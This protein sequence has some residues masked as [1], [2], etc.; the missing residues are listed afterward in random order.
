M[1]TVVRSLPFVG[2]HK[3]HDLLYFDGPILSH[4]LDSH[5]RHVLFYWT[6]FDEGRLAHRWLVWRSELSWILDYLNRRISLLELLR[7]CGGEY[8]YL[9]YM[10]NELN[11]Q[12]I[13]VCEFGEISFEYL[14]PPAVYYDLAIPERYVSGEMIT[15]V[16]RTPTE[17]LTK[18]RESSVYFHLSPRE[19]SHESSV[20]VA[21]AGMFLRRIA[22]SW[23]NF[24]SFDFFDSFKNRITDLKHMQKVVQEMHRRMDPRI[25]DLDYRSFMVGVGVDNI[26][27]IGDND[28]F[29]WQ[30]E[31]VGKYREEVLLIDYSSEE[32][33]KDVRERVAPDRIKLVYSP[34]I[35]IMKSEEYSLEVKDVRTKRVVRYP[36]LDKQRAAVLLEQPAE[37]RSKETKLM[38]IVVEVP[39]NE[40]VTSIGKKQ[41]SDGLLFAQPIDDTVIPFE[42]LT[43]QGI[44]VVFKKPIHVAIHK[45][46]NYYEAEFEDLGIS[47]TGLSK[48]SIFHKL[49]ESVVGL[50]LEAQG[51]KGQ[52]NPKQERL[53]QLVA[54]ANEANG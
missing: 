26:I 4:F 6:G 14:P 42:K 50:Y 30:K 22:T 13:D 37:P 8:Y 34:L 32:V 10:D 27:S 35:D 21:D 44:Q 15:N 29:V 17:Y 46:A 3:Y 31:V 11:H 19:H 53:L 41:I 49:A 51:G 47:L 39:M 36:K 1:K 7:K 43:A 12:H 38:Q 18:V 24:L 20:R 23:S 9:V 28:F 48:E 16:V 40:E 54:Y 5:Q 33:L 52:L 25:Y 45:H 2:L